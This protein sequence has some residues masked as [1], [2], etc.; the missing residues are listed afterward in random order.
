MHQQY[1]K[2]IDAILARLDN[3]RP[4]DAMLQRIQQHVN[5]LSDTYEYDKSLGT[6]RFKLYVA[7]AIL[8]YYQGNEQHAKALMEEAVSVKGHS[9][10][11]AD[12]FLSRISAPTRPQR[13]LNRSFAVKTAGL[14]LVGMF[15][16][17][18]I[19][20][21]I[22]HSGSSGAKADYQATS[23]GITAINPATVSVSFRVT[24]VGSVSGTP[25]CTIE[26]QDPSY[27]YHGVDEFKLP[28]SV[29]PGQTINSADPSITITKQGAAYV[30]AADLKC[31]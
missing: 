25:T 21:A 2:E 31:N 12:E 15:L 23:T 11:F 5:K 30:T 14:V 29:D 16:L 4:G 13:H 28:E 8:D 19:I 17:T 27:A 20:E 3:G 26:V 24:N 9:F 10:G 6:E 18:F 7:Q 1:H 22:S